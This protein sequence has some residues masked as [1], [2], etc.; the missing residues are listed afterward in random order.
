MKDK[1]STPSKA[2][3]TGTINRSAGQLS[4]V[5]ITERWH[6]DG[7]P[8]WEGAPTAEGARAD[9]EALVKRLRRHPFPLDFPGAAELANRLAGCAPDDRCG[10]GACPECTRA[11]QRWLAYY[12][13]KRA[14][15]ALIDRRHRT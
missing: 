13:C 2:P 12:I 11:A 5:Q 14:K 8:H 1:Y 3:D 4:V 15:S 9:R 6:R 10:S 7:D